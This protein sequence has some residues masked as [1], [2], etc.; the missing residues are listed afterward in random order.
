MKTVASLIEEG[1]LKFAVEPKGNPDSLD[2]PSYTIPL[3]E[4]DYPAKTPAMWNA[5][6]ER[7]GVSIRNIMLVGN[8]KFIPQIF[9]AFRQDQKYLGGGAGVG[10]KD[11]AVKYLDELDS[12]AKAIGAVNL[13][14]KTPVGKLKA[15]NTDGLGFAQSLEKRFRKRD[16]GVFGKKVVVL[17]A[18]GAGNAVAFALAQLGAKIVILNR[19]VAKAEDL[20]TRINDYLNPGSESRARF[21]GE[22]LIELEVK[23]ADAIINVSTKGSAGELEQYFALAPAKLPATEE[24]IRE[25]LEKA[26]AVMRLIPRQAV[27]S[28]IVLGKDLTPLLQSAKDAGF[29]VLDGIPMVINQGVE[30]FWILHGRELTEKNITKGDVKNIMVEA[31]SG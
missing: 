4:H 18:G 24:N 1:M 11:E 12:L 6:Y 17:G 23:G 10:F 19:T 25:N 8:P 20:T 3:I 5:V 26:E 2:F 28:D 9:D 31:A 29:E 21:G 30:A 27:I 16:Q 22:D 13:I 15:F 14:I 7:L